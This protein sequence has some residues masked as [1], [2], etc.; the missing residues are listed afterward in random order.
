[1]LCTQTGL[2]VVLTEI[3]AHFIPPDVF[4][5][6]EM[7]LPWKKGH[8]TRVPV[9]RRSRFFSGVQFGPA[10]LEGG[11]CHTGPPANTRL[12]PLLVLSFYAHHSCWSKMG[13]TPARACN[14]QGHN[15]EALASWRRGGCGARFHDGHRWDLV[16][17]SGETLGMFLTISPKIRRCSCCDSV[18]RWGLL[19]IAGE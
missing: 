16:R 13:T 18:P 5:A 17:D 6:V 8:V 12:F 4:A 1:M 19:Q 3:C 10:K 7:I 15:R 14:T 2:G 11:E 9:R